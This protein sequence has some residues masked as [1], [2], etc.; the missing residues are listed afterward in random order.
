MFL[1]YFTKFIKLL[2]KFSMNLS[3]DLLILTVSFIKFVNNGL[4]IIFGCVIIRD[5][6]IIR[7]SKSC[8]KL[9]LKKIF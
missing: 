8:F 9:T 3:N 6:K 7:N 1:V 4:S 5:I 2:Y